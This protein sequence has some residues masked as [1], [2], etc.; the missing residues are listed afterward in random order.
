MKENDCLII[1][2]FTDCATSIRLVVAISAI[3]AVGKQDSDAT[4]PAFP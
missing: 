1:P 3:L 4:L 2:Q